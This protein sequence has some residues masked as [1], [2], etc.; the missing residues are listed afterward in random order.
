[1]MTFTCHARQDGL[2]GLSGLKSYFCRLLSRH[3]CQTLATDAVKGLLD[4]D[5]DMLIRGGPW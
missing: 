1:M 4:A 3:S 5:E 2:N